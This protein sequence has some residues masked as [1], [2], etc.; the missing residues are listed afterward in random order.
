MSFAALDLCSGPNCPRCGCNQS[1]VLQEPSATEG[2]YV[3]AGERRTGLAWF[4]SGRARCGHCGTVFAFREKKA[5]SASLPQSTPTELPATAEARTMPVLTCEKCG[6]TMKISST[7]KTVR[8]H[9]C[10]RCGAT[11]KTPR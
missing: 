5:G 10:P 9:K 6:E 4:A 11:R 2:V 3:K 1:K 7:R 8:W